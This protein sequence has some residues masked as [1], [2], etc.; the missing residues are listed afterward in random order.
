MVEDKLLQELSSHV[1]SEL[2]FLGSLLQRPLAIHYLIQTAKKRENTKEHQSI[3]FSCK[4]RQAV[5]HCDHVKN[6]FFLVL[7]ALFHH[8]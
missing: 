2:L 6:D 7:I 1:R 3:C 5:E 4:Y 8:L